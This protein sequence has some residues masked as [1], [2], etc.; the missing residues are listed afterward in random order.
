MVRFSSLARGTPYK[1]V[2]VVRT[3]LGMRGGKIAAQV[4]HA[5]VGTVLDLQEAASAAG[6]RRSPT[7]DEASS[8]AAIRAANS[9]AALQRWLAQGQAKVVLQIG[10]QA[11]M[12]TLERRA[13]EAGLPTHIVSDAGRTQVA[14]GSET[15]LAVGPAPI[16]LVD[17]IT[18]HLKLL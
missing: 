7:G 17:A 18:G 15:V 10:S 9:V 8:P 2:L 11:A 14:A 16:Q 5:A 6:R 4:A 1:L 13:R 12:H 3:D